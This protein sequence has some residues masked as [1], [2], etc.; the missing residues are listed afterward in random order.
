MVDW[1]EWKRL[2][3]PSTEGR[4]EPI[5]VDYPPSVPD[6]GVLGGHV[7]QYGWL[8]GKWSEDISGMEETWNVKATPLSSEMSSRSGE[9]V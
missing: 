3:Q 5:P 1:F 8:G 4:T 2:G 6:N 7:N 9:T